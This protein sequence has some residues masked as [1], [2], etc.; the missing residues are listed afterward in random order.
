MVFVSV[1]LS[2]PFPTEID[3]SLFTLIEL[4]SF[5]WVEFLHSFLV[6]FDKFFIFMAFLDSWVGIFLLSFAGDTFGLLNI[7]I[8]ITLY[9]VTHIF[10]FVCY[11][12]F[13]LL[14]YFFALCLLVSSF[15]YF[16]FI[17]CISLDFSRFELRE[18]RLLLLI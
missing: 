8:D 4:S 5:L 12:I 17:N 11:S 18:F 9:R 15:L 3:T 14:F 6:R 13:N 16:F 1:H 2:R 10:D 7:V